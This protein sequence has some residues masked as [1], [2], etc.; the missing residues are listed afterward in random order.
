VLDAVFAGTAN[1]LAVSVSSATTFGSFWA[2]R[3]PQI[4]V[5]ATI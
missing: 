5:D 2:A 4:E 3:P 1:D